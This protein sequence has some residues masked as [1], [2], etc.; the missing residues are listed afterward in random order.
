M[1]KLMPVLADPEAAKARLRRFVKAEQ[2][3]D[4]ASARNALAA[5]TLMTRE[6]IL[7]IRNELDPKPGGSRAVDR[8]A[9]HRRS[10]RR[11]PP[12]NC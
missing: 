2:L 8:L 3:A 4:V 1:R 11:R 5:E 9:A 6:D 10:D 7:L 12:R